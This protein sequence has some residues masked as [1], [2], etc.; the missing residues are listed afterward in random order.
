MILRRNKRYLATW[1]AALA[2][3]AIQAIVLAH[4]VKH[5]LHQ[6]DAAC[7]LHFYAE[8]LGKTPTSHLATVAIV[9]SDETPAPPGTV[10]ASAPRAPGYHT[11]APPASRSLN[12]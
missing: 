8:H 11:R 5:D 7:A 12:A 1:F 9:V 6:H 4:E 2:F 3:L 10:A